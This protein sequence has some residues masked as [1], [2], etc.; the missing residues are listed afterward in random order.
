[1][2]V[3]VVVD[4]AVDL[5]LYDLVLVWLDHLVCNS[6]RAVSACEMYV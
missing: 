1:M 3:L 4:L 2:E 6:C 5:L